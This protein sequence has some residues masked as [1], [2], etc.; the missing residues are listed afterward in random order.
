MSHILRSVEEFW[1]EQAGFEAIK[2]RQLRFQHGHGPCN[3]FILDTS[4]SLGED[5]F[6]EMKETFISI[7]DEYAKYPDMDENVAVIV[8][9]KHVRFQRY[10]SNHYE[11]I[12]QCLDDVEFGGPSPLTAAFI[13]SI[14]ALKDGASHTCV[15]NEFKIRPRF[16]LISD[17]RPTSITEDFRNSDDC[18]QMEREEDKHILLNLTS[19]LGKKHPFFCIPVGRRPNLTLLN[20][21]CSHSQGGKLVYPYEARQFARYSRNTNVAATLFSKTRNGCTD[22]EWILMSLASEFPHW[23]FSEQDQDD[24]YEIYSKKSMFCSMDEW[25]SKRH[26][27]EERDPHM[28]T[29]GTRVRRGPDWKWEEQDNY[30][31][32]TVIAHSNEDGWLFVEWDHGQNNA[33]NYRYGPV[34]NKYDVNC[35][36]EPRILCNESI[37][38]GCLVTRGPDWEW[39]NQDGGVGKIGSVINVQGS[40]IVLVRW[41]HGF[42]GKYRF[43]SNDKFDLKI[44]DPFSPEAIRY[45]TDKMQNFNV[46][47]PEHTQPFLQEDNTC[48]PVKNEK[49]EKKTE[50]DWKPRHVLH[51]T[52]GKYFKNKEVDMS[53]SDIETDGLDFPY[54]MKQW[55]WKDGE[56]KWNPYS[57]ETNARI[58]KCHQR[59]PKSTVVVSVNNTSYRV[60]MARNIQI[61][62]ST[63]EISEIKLVEDASNS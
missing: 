5:G 34:F 40:G 58:N 23:E 39:D 61:N 14:G 2:N 9:G 53:S 33:Y 22:K 46:F 62:L 17:G 3:I 47:S 37:A 16:I 8:C 4:S 44:C 38:T 43:G 18:R 52:K 27:F 19:Q 26:S 48:S 10:Y 60:V 20:L 63:R 32:G 54:A 24:I 36:N 12:K 50:R 41:Q 25:E 30:E 6:K 59:D 42:I 45:A 57:R 49:L 56:G 11:D 28:P 15:M 29:L 7:I 31:P 55:F 1:Q 51:V 13:L 35:C 21:L